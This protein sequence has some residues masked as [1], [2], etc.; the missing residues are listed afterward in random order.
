MQSTVE[1]CQA[2]VDEDFDRVLGLAGL[3]QPARRLALVGDRGE[4]AD[5][6]RPGQGQRRGLVA[7]L[8]SPRPSPA[9]AAGRRRARRLQ[10]EDALLALGTVGARQVATVGER[11]R[12]GEVEL[13]ESE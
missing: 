5:R 9:P 12:P 1:Q 8:D 11:Q 4:G 10:D 6:S 13:D 3:V 7:G 2:F